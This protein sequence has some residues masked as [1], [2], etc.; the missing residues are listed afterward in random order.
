MFRAQNIRSKVSNIFK[1]KKSKVIG[2][3]QKKKKKATNIYKREKGQKSLLTLMHNQ[4][5]L[6][7]LERKVFVSSRGKLLYH[8]HFSFL[9][10]FNQTTF[11]SSLSFSLSF[12]SKQTDLKLFDKIVIQHLFFS[13]FPLKSL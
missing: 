7:I 13:F 2:F 10:L 6:S 3:P 1:K 12:L 9:H 5:F 4:F 11:F 8:T